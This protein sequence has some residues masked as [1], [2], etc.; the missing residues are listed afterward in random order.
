MFVM[1]TAETVPLFESYA[2]QLVE[3]WMKSLDDNGSAVLPVG[4]DLART[5]CIRHTHRL[6]LGDGQNLFECYFAFGF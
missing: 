3:Y 1:H 2:Q 4:A 6:Y 5:V